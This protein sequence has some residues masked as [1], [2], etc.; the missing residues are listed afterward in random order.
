MRSNTEKAR[1]AVLS[2]PRSTEWERATLA[3]ME[4]EKETR[5]ESFYAGVGIGFM[6]GALAAIW[7][8]SGVAEE[9]ERKE[10][11]RINFATPEPEKR[12]YYS[13]D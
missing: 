10:I 3:C 2:D 8:Y 7:Y 11:E 6:F 5:W 12:S 4:R 13:T 1:M 9:R